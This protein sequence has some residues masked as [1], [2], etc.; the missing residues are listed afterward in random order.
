MQTIVNL[1]IHLKYQGMTNLS[2]CFAGLE[3]KN[4]I[5]I[6]SSGLTNST[7]DIK[8]L[9]ESGAAA[10]VLKSLFE[11]EIIREMQATYS[12]MS[13]EGYLY[14]ET[15]DFYEY[16]DTQE[17]ST[18]RYLDLITKTKKEVS[19][20]VIAS[21]NCLTAS[22][23]TYFPQQIERSGADALEL[24]IFILPSDL[25]RSAE[26]NEKVYH[27]II[28]EVL[29][30]IKIPVIVKLSFYFSNL[31]SFLQDISKT[32]IKGLVLFNRFYN[33]D[34]D[35]NK[36][37]ITSGAVL[38]DPSDL[39]LSLRWIAIMAERVSCDLA[40]STG[41]HDGTALIKQLLAGAHAV[42]IASTL[43]RNGNAQ[44]GEMIKEVRDWMKVKG[45]DSLNDFRGKLSQ[46]KSN[47]PAAYERIQFMKYFR[48]YQ[49][50]Q[51]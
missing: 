41:V 9:E 50:D 20:P 39:F 4:P 10:V 16:Q 21:I 3:L 5:I 12:S 40:A 23:W 29:K 26:E 38:S 17:D 2:T 44:I 31:A 51:H 24:N 48:G 47:N 11:E 46:A 6:G 13:S 45:Y 30:Q 27:D 14:P 28:H 25:N 32:G 37:E 49:K 1:T 42:E 15:L 22:Q 18:T 33:P 43:Y 34:F 35:L 8:E 19:I 7:K 36:L